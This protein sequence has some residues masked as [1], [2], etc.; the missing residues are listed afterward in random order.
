VLV[1]VLGGDSKSVEFSWTSNVAVSSP[2]A[3]YGL[4]FRKQAGTDADQIEVSIN[5]HDVEL[6]ADPRFALTKVGT[7]LYN[8]TLARDL[9]SR[10]YW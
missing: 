2:L 7:Y 8:T 9:F 3:S 6:K 5:D 4:Y 10:F 1:E